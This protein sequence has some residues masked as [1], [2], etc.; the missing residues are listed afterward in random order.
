MRLY[1]M[2]HQSELV[3]S[4]LLLTSLP[5][6]SA[7][8]RLF[9]IIYRLITRLLRHEDSI[10]HLLHPSNYSTS[11]Q[12][13]RNLMTSSSPYLDVERVGSAGHLGALLAT[14][15]HIATSMD[16]IQGWIE[17]DD[18]SELQETLRALY[19]L[20]YLP[21][22]KREVAKTLSQPRCFELLLNCV[23]MK[24]QADDD[25]TGDHYVINTQTLTSSIIEA[26]NGESEKQTMTSHHYK[27]AVNIS[28]T[29]LFLNIVKYSDDVTYLLRHVDMIVERCVT[30]EAH[31]TTRSNELRHWLKP[32]AN[33]DAF[34]DVTQMMT[35]LLDYVTQNCDESDKVVTSLP[36]FCIAL[37]LLRHIC[38]VGEFTD[39]VINDFNHFFSTDDITM[40]SSMKLQRVTQLVASGGFNTFIKMTE[41]VVTSLNDVSRYN[42]ALLGIETHDVITIFITHQIAFLRFFTSYLIEANVAVDVSRMTSSLL[43]I[44][45]IAF[46]LLWWIDFSLLHVITRDVIAILV[47]LLPCSNDSQV[48][49]VMTS[50]MK[51]R[52]DHFIPDLTLL[53]NL[54]PIP[55]PLTTTDHCTA[56]HLSQTL[57]Q[58][59]TIWSQAL[60]P[61]LDDLIAFMTSLLTSSCRPLIQL[62][63]TCLQQIIDVCDVT[64][65]R[66]V[67]KLIEAIPNKDVETE[68]GFSRDDVTA[69][70]TICEVMTLPAARA[71]FLHLLRHQ[72]SLDSHVTQVFKLAMTSE[73]TQTVA[74]IMSLALMTLDLD[75]SLMTSSNDYLPIK[76]LC[77]VINLSVTCLSRHVSNHVIT[78]R[79]TFAILQ[80]V[81]DK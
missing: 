65:S 20:L 7:H 47:A 8:H 24:A 16:A 73:D 1:R 79:A 14:H 25:V 42:V 44:H 23:W 70:M 33:F 30:S 5:R 28:A 41:N 35:K 37:R 22:G 71:A 11:F 62:L 27:S 32:L 10:F 6:V 63:V 34:D 59:S 18:V 38:G 3:T 40:T 13:A 49:K 78:E 17:A 12:L 68:T 60:Q 61:A 26:K 21:W 51:S 39:D 46:Q 2:S 15:L 75:A 53:T 66:V 36:G 64:A 19:G 54:L 69:L 52:C 67:T 4:L 58:V 31:V 9:S 76:L 55:L 74:V 56:A 48:L 57:T 77:D 43:D 80:I 72:P 45:V 29:L 81:S 50:H